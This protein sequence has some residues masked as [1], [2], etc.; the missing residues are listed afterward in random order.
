MTEK[1]R[2]SPKEMM[3]GRPATEKLGA[4]ATSETQASNSADEATK[5][6]SHEIKN[7]GSVGQGCTLSGLAEALRERTRSLHA[8]AERSG[9]IREILRGRAS[10]DGY[11]LLLRNLLP[12]YRQMELGFER[13]QLTPGVRAVARPVVYRTRALEADLE[14]LH[15]R[16]WS[17]S[18]PLLAAGDRYARRIAAVAKGSGSGLIAHAYVRYLGDLNGGQVL[19]RM[20]TRSLGLGPRTLSFHDFPEIADLQGFKT[21]YR[22]AFDRAALEIVD[23]GSVVD[24]AAIAFRLNI[25]VSKAILETLGWSGDNGSTRVAPTDP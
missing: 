11:A 17:Q 4:E 22:Q 24:E 8:E 23:V 16:A 1:Y 5:S 25:E 10:R 21:D 3:C 14:S 12:A 6:H 20:L 13:H 2:L 7:P 15:G 18:L 9:F 19:K